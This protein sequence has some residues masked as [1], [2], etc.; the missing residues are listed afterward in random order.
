MKTELLPVNVL[1]LFIHR[2][3]HLKHYF[4]QNKHISIKAKLVT[5]KISKQYLSSV[6]T[7]IN[8]FVNGCHCLINPVLQVMH[9]TNF[10]AINNIF[11]NPRKK[12]LQGV[13][14]GLQSIDL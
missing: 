8:I 3:C 11:I 12:K 10:L 4:L 6:Q 9:I 7:L 13:R 5:Q 2:N 1:M 14:S